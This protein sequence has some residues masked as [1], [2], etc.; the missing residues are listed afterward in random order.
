L[1]GQ[2]RYRVHPGEHETF[3]QAVQEKLAS[4]V[5]VVA[6][7]AG[8]MLDLVRDGDNGFL[9]LPGRLGDLRERVG[10]LAAQPELRRQM[11][12]AARL[13]VQDRGWDRFGDLLIQHYRDVRQIHALTAA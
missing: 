2:L 3:G 8:G 7:A 13:S 10:R 11:G 9:Y 12:A 6:V 1:H 4:G 5:P